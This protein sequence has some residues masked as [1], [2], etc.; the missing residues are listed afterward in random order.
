M[1]VSLKSTNPIKVI[2]T[3]KLL[4]FCKAFHFMALLSMKH[5]LNLSTHDDK[6]KR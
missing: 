6:C 5:N 1:S 2:I 4:I 3:R